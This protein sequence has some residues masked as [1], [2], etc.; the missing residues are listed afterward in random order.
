MTSVGDVMATAKDHMAKSVEATRRELAA[1]RT[2]RASTGLVEHVR[3]DLHGVPTPINHMAS[4]NV[5]EARMLTIQPW[6]RGMLGAIE[7]AIQKSDLGLTPNND[8]NMIRLAI[9]SL[10]EQRRKELTKLVQKRVEDGRVAIRNI[11][12]DASDHLRRLEK[13]KE[14]SGDE[15]RRVQDQLQKLTDS[16]VADVEKL[17]H[18]KEQEL[19]EV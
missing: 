6:D 18:E 1:V 19:L 15:A 11:R 17:G 16:N 9:P 10:N 13:S 2:G 3:V 8:G 14:I 5:P 7:K 12:R 4:V